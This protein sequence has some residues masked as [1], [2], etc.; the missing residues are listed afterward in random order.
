MS[1]RSVSV[2]EAKAHLSELIAA[3]EAGEAVVITKRGKAVARLVSE[4]AATAPAKID[5]GW[6]REMTDGMPYQEEDAG[7]FLR[8]VRDG[9]RY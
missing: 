8:R 5:L 2:A 4:T 3:V 6:L 9:D 1:E 7:A